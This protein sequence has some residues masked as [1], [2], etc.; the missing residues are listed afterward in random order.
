[1]ATWVEDIIQALKNLGGHGTLNQIYD[2]VVQIRTEELPSTYKSSV[3][4]K[5][6]SYSSDSALYKG[7]DIFKKIDKGV[8][9]LRDININFEETLIQKNKLNKSIHKNQKMMEM[10]EYQHIFKT[11][12]DYRSYSD[13]EQPGWHDYIEELFNILGYTLEPLMSNEILWNKLR[14]QGLYSF[15]NLPPDEPKLWLMNLIGDQKYPKALVGIALPADDFE[16]FIPGFRWV[17]HLSFSARA[18][19]IKWIILT[20]GLIIKIWSVQNLKIWQV[21]EIEKIIRS[22]NIQEF[23]SL[24][25]KL[26]LVSHYFPEN[27]NTKTQAN[28]IL[29]KKYE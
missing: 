7:L 29:Y 18:I 26:F 11:I 6:E 10:D 13:P 19:K 14:G 4:D 21:Y 2:E 5:L 25:D 16:Y 22:E 20:N 24:Y 3:R 8:W 12:L 28:K 1:M 17:G 9:G 27:I 15:F 23:K